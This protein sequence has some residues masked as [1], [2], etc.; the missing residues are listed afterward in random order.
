MFDNQI[1]KTDFKNS[2]IEIEELKKYLFGRGNEFDDILLIDAECSAKASLEYRFS[3]EVR[4]FGIKS[5]YTEIVKFTC[6]IEWT[7]EKTQ[8]LGE[9]H[10]SMLLEKGG[11]ESKKDITGIIKIDTS[12]EEWS[13]TNTVEF[14][15]DGGYFFG[16]AYVNLPD[17]QI[18]LTT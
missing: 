3:A 10:I 7:I 2:S 12:K 9:G 13:F 14:E 15:S 5:I 11:I 18:V 4:K 17:K 1:F 16:L 6:E 8:Y